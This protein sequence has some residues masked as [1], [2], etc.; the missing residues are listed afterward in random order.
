MFEEPLLQEN[1]AA[2]LWR[3]LR[4]YW[5]YND[6]GLWF[7]LTA[8]F[9]YACY[10]LIKKGSTAVYPGMF[11]PAAAAQ[12]SSWASRG[13]LAA[14]CL[15][16]AVVLYLLET[17]LFA[18]S[19]LMGPNTT[20]SFLQ[21]MAPLFGQNGRLSPIA[22]FDVNMLYAFSHNYKLL[23][24]YI[25]LQFG[26]IVGL[27][28]KF[29]DWYPASRRLWLCG[30]I[31]LL[32]SFFWV[33]SLVFPE[34]LML[35]FMLLG[36]IRL[37]NYSRDGRFSDLG[38]FVLWMNL[39]LYCKESVI[40][41]YAGFFVFLLLWDVWREKI[42]LSSFL[43]PWRSC[44]ALPLE[45]LMLVSLLIYALFY[46]VKV[47]GFTQSGYMVLRQGELTHLL[48][49]YKT[50]LL[51][52]VLAAVMVLQ[53]F[54]RQRASIFEGALLAGVLLNAAFLV[55]FLRLCPFSYFVEAK[56]YYLL[57]AAFFALP[58]CF[59]NWPRRLFAVAV[60][61][62][63]LWSL[64]ENVRLYRRE[65][66]WYYR[67]VAEFL[68]PRL[69]EKDPAVIYISAHSEAEKWW[70]SSWAS[71]YKYYFPHQKIIFASD[72]YWNKRDLNTL[73]HLQIYA[74]QPAVFH[75]V[76]PQ[77]HP[78]SGNFYVIK[79]IP[80]TAPDRKQLQRFPNRLLHENKLFEV[81]EIL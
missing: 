70:F 17:T 49:L 58:L 45:S 25:L 36:F 77:E 59:S 43:H 73:L 11:P 27:L 51:I 4:F 76:R 18:N 6:Y 71:A 26:L 46:L 5:G 61:G 33:N 72:L 55:F 44:R 42:T 24:L 48:Q 69:K 66:G 1:I 57:P 22:F 37:R 53:R 12:K 21:G 56:S 3:N 13:F 20:R 67:D 74:S 78:E 16:Y 2:V 41:I 47:S 23:N 31:V 14:A 39:A 28:Y 50:E 30:I 81:Y 40:L 54:C 64:C 9:L 79:K 52:I 15:A 63:V 10:L 35:I 80:D 29:L 75:P 68:A 60:L 7:L 19:D 65:A 38:G 34:R 62:L 32:P 8:A